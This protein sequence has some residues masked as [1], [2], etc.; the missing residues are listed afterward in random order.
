MSSNRLTWLFGLQS[1]NNRSAIA[2]SKLRVIRRSRLS[3]YHW[4]LLSGMLLSA[5]AIVATARTLDVVVPSGRAGIVG[6]TDVV[7]STLSGPLYDAGA[8]VDFGF[9]AVSLF[10]N[11]CSASRHDFAIAKGYSQVYGFRLKPTDINGT[12][13]GVLLVHGSGSWERTLSSGQRMVGVVN[14]IQGAWQNTWNVNGKRDRLSSLSDG[15]FSDQN[16]INCPNVVLGAGSYP[17]Y[18]ASATRSSSLRVVFLIDAPNGGLRPG[19]YSINKLLHIDTSLNGKGDLSNLLVDGINV[20]V[21]NYSCSLVLSRNRVELDSTQDTDVIGYRVSCSD[22]T[23]SSN[24]KMIP[25]LS[26]SASGSSQGLSADAKHLGVVESGNKLSVVGSW[27]SSPPANCS[28]EGP[29]TIYFDGRD[30]QELPTVEPTQNITTE[31][32]L[33]FRLCGAKEAATGDYRAYA[34]LSVVQR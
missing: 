24:I 29:R 6:Q 23:P 17:F 15:T 26:L 2:L 10:S 9:P 11:G 32:N 22:G 19:Y 18:N 33:A 14:F 27:S 8:V 1:I 4:Q 3:R 25:Y 30:G 34:T 21:A 13:G 5:S 7:T 16:F 20:I 12:A 31:G 28:E